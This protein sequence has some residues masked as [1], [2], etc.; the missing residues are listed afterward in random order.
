[1]LWDMNAPL[2]QRL[3]V[4]A[5]S[6]GMTISVQAQVKTEVPDIVPGAK[7]VRGC[8]KR[9]ATSLAAYGASAE[10]SRCE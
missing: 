1:M 2:I 9:A 7:P 3:T 8:L 10:S 4:M 6:L 5:I